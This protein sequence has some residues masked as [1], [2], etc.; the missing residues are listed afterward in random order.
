M[1]QSMIGTL[2]IKSVKCTNM[3][4][5]FLN[6]VQTD[7]STWLQKTFVFIFKLF[8]L[9]ISVIHLLYL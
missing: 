8:I 4:P 6:F 1:L 2:K 7:K 9:Y 5:Q 3:L